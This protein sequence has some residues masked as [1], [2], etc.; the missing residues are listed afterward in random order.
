MREKRNESV[1]K[2]EDCKSKKQNTARDNYWQEIFINRAPTVF[3]PSEYIKFP[4]SRSR[5]KEIYMT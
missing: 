3:C 1:S 5:I 2:S 4:R